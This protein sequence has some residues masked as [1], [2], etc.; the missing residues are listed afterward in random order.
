MLAHASFQVGTR[1][2]ANRDMYHDSFHVGTCN[3]AFDSGTLQ[4]PKVD[5]LRL[6]NSGCNMCSPALALAQRPT[7]PWCVVSCQRRR[8]SWVLMQRSRAGHAALKS[9][10][11]D[12]ACMEIYVNM[13]PVVWCCG[14]LANMQQN[15]NALV[16]DLSP[17]MPYR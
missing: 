1:I 2:T 14:N 4:G 9:K 6:T 16:C 15:V 5:D 11:H 8:K 10:T 17:T 3:I 12:V 7:T 13:A